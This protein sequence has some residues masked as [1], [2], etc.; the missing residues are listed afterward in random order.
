MIVH[1]VYCHTCFRILSSCAHRHALP[2][3][4]MEGGWSLWERIGTLVRSCKRSITTYQ[5]LGAP[6]SI[7]NQ[8]PTAE[9]RTSQK[10]KRTECDSPIRPQISPP[11]H[12]AKSVHTTTP[13]RSPSA[14]SPR[15][16]FNTTPSVPTSSV[17]TATRSSTKLLR[18]RARTW[19]SASQRH[20]P[21][22]LSPH[23]IAPTPRV[24]SPVHAPSLAVEDLGHASSVNQ[25]ASESEPHQC[26]SEGTSALPI[27]L[28]FDPDSSADAPEPDVSE[29]RCI[30]AVRDFLRV[31]RPLSP[32]KMSHRQAIGEILA[33]R[34]LRESQSVD[35][36]RAPPRLL[37]LVE[38]VTQTDEM[39]MSDSG[40]SE[41]TDN[42]SPT[43]QA[44]SRR[45][46]QRLMLLPAEY[47]E[48]SH[49][50]GNRGTGIVVRVSWYGC[51]GTGISTGIVIWVSG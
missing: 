36:E 41:I 27:D 8:L 19:K 13:V 25:T 33:A 49:A 30:R 34:L 45:F 1:D 5:Y 38:A 21:I 7:S 17:A 18:H 23:P 14:P 22:P 39:A 3:S 42:L 46:R 48:V 4:T 28:R 40:E 2:A 12:A 20:S 11:H 32:P 35:G 50:C 16:W 29:D 31:T 6:H 24:K 9:Q 43:A 15:A 44:A 51:R 37:E 26:S 47:D 10:R